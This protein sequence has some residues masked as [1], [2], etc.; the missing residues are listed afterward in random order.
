MV[1]LKKLLIL[2]ILLFLLGGCNKVKGEIASP[3]YP[4][5]TSFEITNKK[6]YDEYL[7]NNYL[8][9]TKICDHKIYLRKD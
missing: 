3:V 4:S 6:E 7:Q 1:S 5:K 9:D 8:I 2:L